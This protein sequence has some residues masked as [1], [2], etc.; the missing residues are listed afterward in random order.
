MK[1]PTLNP[2]LL[3]GVPEG[4]WVSISRDQLTVLATGA[5]LDEAHEGAKRAGEDSPF[6]IRVC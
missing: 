5:T 6:V 1:A 4:S 3:E 2:E